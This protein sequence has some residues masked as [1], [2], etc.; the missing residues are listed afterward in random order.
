MHS[1]LY[2]L[3][4]QEGCLIQ[5]IVQAESTGAQGCPEGFAQQ[6]CFVLL[7]LWLL[8]LGNVL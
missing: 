2:L 8:S 3:S 5:Q 1:L 7:L 6:T 4:F